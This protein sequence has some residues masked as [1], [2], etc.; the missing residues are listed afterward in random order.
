MAKDLADYPSDA[1]A[2][3]LQVCRRELSG[4]LTLAAILQR[5]N[6][7]DGR[8][9]RD[10]AWAIALQ[11][12]DERETVVMTA[13][14]QKA[15]IAAMPILK[16]GDKVG[17][18]MAFLSAYDRYCAEAR[19]QGAPVKWEVSLGF[20]SDRRRAAIE[21]AQR[22]GLLPPADA[23]RE[24][25]RLEYTLPP[26]ETGA[27][28]AGL[29]TGRV[30]TPSPDS[31]ERIAQLKADLAASQ[32][33]KAERLHR[34]AREALDKLNQKKAETAAAIEELERSKRA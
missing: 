14:I 22:Q 15:L 30:F 16:L 27:A 9:G 24:L 1:V 19:N 32:R 4:K 25:A 10:E 7:A 23:T 5:I 20:D 2:A 33:E 28:I 17:A 31:R 29:I 3:A 12:S 18:R 13:E 34:E 26:S 11:G 8:P 21:D 6:A